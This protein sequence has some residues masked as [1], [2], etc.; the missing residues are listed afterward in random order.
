MPE[1]INPASRG[2]FCAPSL[3]TLAELARFRGEPADAQ[4]RLSAFVR[5]QIGPLVVAF[6]RRVD[7]AL[8]LVS[9][10]DVNGQDALLAQAPYGDDSR[11]L[12]L[13]DPL[14]LALAAITEAQ[15]IDAPGEG[16]TARLLGRP[17]MVLCAPMVVDGELPHAIILGGARE[18]LGA[19][20]PSALGVLLNL[21][22]QLIGRGL[23]ARNLDAQPPPVRQQL[24]DLA[25]SQR[26]LQPDNLAL[27]G[28]RYAV[29][30]QPAEIAAGDY[31]DV[32]RLTHRVPNHPTDLGD[33]VGTILADVSGHGAGAA[34][35][36]A[37]FDA[38][39]RTYRGTDGEGPAAALTYANRYF[40]SRRQRRHFMTVFALL[41]HPGEGVVRY[42]NAGHLP[43]LRLS[44]GAISRIGSDGDIPIGVVRDHT[45]TNQ[46]MAYVAGDTFVLYSDGISEAR[47]PSGA[48]FG[49]DQLEAE[50]ARGPREPSALLAHLVDAVIAHQRGPI[51]TDDQTLLVIQ[52]D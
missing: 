22:Y 27:R 26:L 11:L 37:Q 36:A 33:V 32:A 42:C 24:R 2:V 1:P 50:F 30:Y 35:E 15:F 13:D 14:A 41:V 44:D 17:Q 18:T 31:Y 23:N 29:H 46:R 34:L 45:F 38:I 25:D 20:D 21:A 39:L 52:L 10:S 8:R 28:Y 43:A 19:F 9:L 48:M 3:A 16:A 12:K 40:F 5:E 7:R 6:V 49:I 4:R 51:G 47:D